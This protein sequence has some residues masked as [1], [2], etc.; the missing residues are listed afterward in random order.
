MMSLHVARSGIASR[1]LSAQLLTTG[2]RIYCS[3]A[4]EI[5][6]TVWGRLLHA[7]IALLTTDRTWKGHSAPAGRK[8]VNWFF[9][10]N[11][12]G[13]PPCT[14]GQHIRCMRSLRIWFFPATNSTMCV[15][16]LLLRRIIVITREQLETLTHSNS[17]SI[18]DV[19]S[20]RVRHIPLLSF[21]SGGLL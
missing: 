14:H 7:V 8:L 12:C 18:F 9:H 15:I 10:V 5:S 19:S 20:P 13:S 6:V 21:C 1:H 11:P 3:H 2:R 16:R 17:L 4:G